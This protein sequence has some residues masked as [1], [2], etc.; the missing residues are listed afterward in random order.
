MTASPQARPESSREPMRILLIASVFP[1]VTGGSANVYAAFARQL[2]DRVLVLAPWRNYVDGRP[3][4]DWRETDARQPFPV[5]RVELL[6]PALKSPP[7]VPFAGTLW[8]SVAG[9][10]PLRL[11]VWRAANAAVRRF[12][13]AVVCLGELQSLAWLGN[14]LRREHGIPILHFA[15]GEELTAT[16]VSRFLEIEARQ[17]LTSAETVVAVS[18]FTRGVLLQRGVPAGRIHLITNGVDSARFVP[19]PK[20]REITERHGLAGK[21]VLL[22]VGRLEERKGQDMVVRALPA[23]LEA[24]PDCFYVVA[25]QGTYLESV[26]RMTADLGLQ[27]RVVFAGMVR[28][29]ELVD[30]YR[31]ADVVIMP[32]RTLAN[33]DTEGFGL[34]FLEA[35]ACGKPVIG[36]LDGGVPDAVEDG[37]TGLLVNGRSVVEVARAAARLLTDTQLSA[38]LGE[39]GRR[40]AQNADWKHKARDF[41]MACRAACE[42]RREV[43]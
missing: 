29:Q 27:D 35:G 25:G 17:A 34:V 36:G 1:P 32:N 37:V 12:R 3:I 26:K 21:R 38:R 14:M 22:T 20:S 2:Y 15:H 13:P 41:E 11:E 30:Y 31:T 5:R 4:P 40:R 7:P 19:G 39:A 16:A 9:D 18:S 24:V 6:R 23:I 10:L 33:G 43:L 42:R 28:E 8:R